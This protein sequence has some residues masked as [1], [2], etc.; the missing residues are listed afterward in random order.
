MNADH[1]ASHVGRCQGLVTL[2]RATA[3]HASRNKV[4]TP[5]ELLIKVQ[6]YPIF[7][8]TAHHLSSRR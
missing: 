2:L 3:F 7:L 6:L 8:I 4:Y 1:V 5:V